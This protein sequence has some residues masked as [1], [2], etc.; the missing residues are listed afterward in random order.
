MKNGGCSLKMEEE[1]SLSHCTCIIHINFYFNLCMKSILFVANE[2]SLKYQ[3]QQYKPVQAVLT[4]Y[5]NP[6]M[7]NSLLWPLSW[8]PV[9]PA[10]EHSQCTMWSC[11]LHHNTL[12][13]LLN[14]VHMLQTHLRK[15]VLEWHHPVPNLNYKPTCCR[16]LFAIL[17]NSNLT[18]TYSLLINRIM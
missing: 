17:T 18:Y 3:F 2:V 14:P 13:R 16:M 8:H 9:L 10:V 4:T 5:F 7:Q 1:S 12:S 11:L 15:A 6:T